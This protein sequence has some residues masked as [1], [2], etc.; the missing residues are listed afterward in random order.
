M[1][2]HTAHLQRRVL[3]NGDGAP[4]LGLVYHLAD[5]WVPELLAAHAAQ[6][7]PPAALAA[8]LDPPTELL[9]RIGTN[10]GI[11]RVRCPPACAGRLHRG[12][13][14]HKCRA[15]P[16]GVVLAAPEV[17]GRDPGLPAGVVAC[18]PSAPCEDS[19]S[20][21]FLKND[22]DAAARCTLDRNS[23][24]RSGSRGSDT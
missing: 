22:C 6:A 4:D 18:P 1:E 19:R 13:S 10:A 14:Q 11:E 20:S 16:C 8:L 23:G 21:S 9:A 24:G 15:H 17:Y 12:A 7:V 5:C 3:L 2:R